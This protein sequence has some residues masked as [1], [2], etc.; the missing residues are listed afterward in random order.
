VVDTVVRAIET[1]KKEGSRL[2][3]QETGDYEEADDC[4]V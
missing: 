4:G 1:T 3:Y 2:N